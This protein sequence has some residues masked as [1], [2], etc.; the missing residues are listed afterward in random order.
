MTVVAVFVGVPGAGKSTVGALVAESIG[1]NFVDTDEQIAQRAGKPVGDIFVE[2]GE[3]AFRQLEGETV[4]ELFAEL[5]APSSA[6]VPTVVALGGGA[7]LSAE[8]RKQLVDLPVVWLTVDVDNTVRRVGLNAP[9]PVL[10]GNV[11]GQVK[12]LMAERAP[13]YEAVST[14]TVDTTERNAAEVVQQVML[15]LGLDPMDTSP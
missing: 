9:R 13:L 6:A 8:T 4:T 15:E 3:D 2:D 10:L 14:I 7:V 11:R 12:A 1:A 5:A